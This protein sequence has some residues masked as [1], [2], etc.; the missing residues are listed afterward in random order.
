MRIRKRQAPYPISSLS[1]VPLSDLRLPVVQFHQSLFQEDDTAAYFN[2][3][4]SSDQSSQ[5]I[6]DDKLETKDCPVWLNEGE[7]GEKG[8]DFRVGSFLS[9]DTETSMVTKEKSFPLKKRIT[10]S[11]TSDS[12][13]KGDKKMKTKMNKKCDKNNQDIESVSKRRDRGG[14]VLMEGSR[15]SRVNGRG[16]RCCQQTL[17]GYSLCEHHLGKGR[18]RS[19]TSVRT[20]PALKKVGAAKPLLSLGSDVKDEQLGG[21]CV[22]MDFCEE[23]NEARSEEK[24]PLMMNSMSKRKLGIVKARSISSLLGQ[25]DNV[26]FERE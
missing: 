18:L 11:V 17:V 16:W 24:K 23:D 6:R 10:G 21:D 7:E 5:P 3:P 2:P 26:A 8:N 20:R 22:E 13:E 14:A 1:P 12:E 25:A 9:A 19:M 4:S 15:C